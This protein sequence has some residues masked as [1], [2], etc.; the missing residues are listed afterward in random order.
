MIPMSH[1]RR[2]AAGPPLAT[3][4]EETMKL[5]ITGASHFVNRMFEACGS[6]QWAREF[7]K[8]SIEAGA[9]KVEFGVEWQAVEKLGRY[10]RTI[11]DNGS[12]MDQKELLSFFSTLGHGARKIGGI[13]DNF[14]VGARIACLPWNPEGLV[15]ISY[16]H[17][18][19]SMIWI[20]LDDESGDY[21]LMEFQTPNGASHVIEPQLV[22]E[23]D[24]AV[25][26][27]DW[28]TDH[29][30]VIVL[31]G[32]EE[33]PDTILGNPQSGESAIKGLSVYLNT[34]FWD[35]AGVDVRVV[36]LRSEKK[37]QWPERPDDRDDSR[38][39]NNRQIKG[40]RHWLLDVTGT[41]GRLADH[42]ALVLDGERVN[43]EWYLWAG[44]RPHVDSYA[45]RNGY[46]ALRYKGEL[47]QVTSN[48]AHF[49][50]FG[51]VEGKVQQNLSLIIE[52][53]L[54]QH[55]NGRWGVHPDQSRNRLIFTGNSEKG[56]DVPLSDWGLEFSER[57]P[58]PVLA[59]IRA[60]RGEQS[61]SIE[62][63]EY[64]KR[65][66]DRFGDRWTLKVFVKGRQKNRA[67]QPATLV[68]DGAGVEVFDPPD[69]TGSVD[70]GGTRRKRKKTVKV[71]RA[72]VIV[73]GP[74]EGIERRMPVDVPRFRIV[75]KDEFE[76]P[77]HI[78]GWAPNDQGGPT[79]M[80]N[81]ESPILQE[82][83]QYHQAQY[84]DVFAEEVQKIVFEVFGEVATCK[85]A[86][87]QKLLRNIPREEL[88]TTYRSEQALTIGLMGLMAEESL[89]AQRLGRLGRKK[90]VNAVDTPVVTAQS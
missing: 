58:D 54:Y 66:Q 43:V 41:E 16:K 80:I 84:P 86:H 32:S 2:A 78:A 68:D 30:T 37:T 8:N 61:G 90:P 76:K 67:P 9:K 17:G 5:A 28:I 26:R 20:V 71:L 89:I 85:V 60:V 56:I 19:G 31:L 57:M 74:D 87:S 11:M 4:E 39:P 55:N 59:A 18:K 88:D 40:A 46:I 70:G 27:P 72:P 33:Y 79:V 69:S 12:G 14:G 75:G 36:E 50:W 62:N 65:L 64:R 44:E 3:L 23:V 6:Y 77:W 22:E 25:I 24:W 82:V 52:P 21:E 45:K 15:V 51:V 73:G 63:E 13:H 42:G 7:L 49:R 81:Q 48:K 10:R 34:R 53:Q 35:L 38:R 83:V 47:F 1:R 29:G